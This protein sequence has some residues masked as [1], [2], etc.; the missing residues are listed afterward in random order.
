MKESNTHRWLQAQWRRDDMHMMRDREFP[1]EGIKSDGDTSKKIL[2]GIREDNDTSKEIL[3]GISEL[4]VAQ[5]SD[6]RDLTRLFCC[7]L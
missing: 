2:E 7:Y 6:D 3:A 1:L 4:L 5:R